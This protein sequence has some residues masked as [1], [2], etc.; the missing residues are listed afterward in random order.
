MKNS[1]RSI[2]TATCLLL[3]ATVFAQAPQAFNYQAVARNAGGQ[4]LANQNVGIRFTVSDA[5]S[6]GN[7]LFTETHAK[8]T[9]QFGLFTAEVGNGTAG[10]GTFST[11]NWGAGNR[12]LKVE[13]DP[14]GGTSYANLGT[15]QLLS[16][17]YA[18]YAGNTTAA[19]ATGT[20]GVK[21][22]TGE[23]GDTGAQGNAATDDQTLSWN[24]TNFT[25]SIS[26]GN[27]VV[28]PISGG[29]VGPTGNP[30]AAGANGTNGAMGATGAKGAT[31]DKGAT[32]TAGINGINGTN[33]TNGA[34][35]AT[36]VTGQAG[37]KYSTASA[38][39]LTISAG[40]KTLTVGTGLAYAI[41]QTVIIANSATNVMTGTV[42]AYNAATQT[43]TWNV[44]TMT[45]QS[46]RLFYLYSLM[47]VNAVLGDSV[48][49]TA[50]ASLT[51]ADVT[52]ANNTDT[53]ARLISGSY[54]PNDKA[55][56]PKGTGFEGKITPQDT[57]LSYFIRFQN[58]GT[59]TAFTVIIRDTLDSDL[60][61]STFKFDGASHPLEYTISGEGLVTF[62]FNN[63][64]L[65]DSFVNEPASHGYI[66]YF[67]D[68]KL[69]I[70]LGTQITNTAYIYFDFN[71]PIITNTTLNT[72]WDETV[73]INENEAFA[74]DIF[75][76]P[77][78]DNAVLKFNATE[79]IVSM[80][81]TDLRGREVYFTTSITH[82]NQIQLNRSEFNLSEG[83]YMVNLKTKNSSKTKRWVI[84]GK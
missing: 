62:T 55:V 35:G 3:S 74:F 18:L 79:P 56:T 38:T 2:I 70:P 57:T 43:A 65:A 21:G 26:G 11:I 33:G 27:S 76:N 36:G 81:I 46:S 82:S 54:D 48:H 49:A 72:L 37:D 73:G 30:G 53:Y 23:K 51:G 45:P 32:G 8:S 42:T 52:P 34:I 47:P 20:T 80:S 31:G 41:G 59:D 9:N 13:I 28:L 1:I 60:D 66:R 40:S 58:T 25:L 4:I 83:I 14:A 71:L 64:L 44:P 19:G 67:I 10:T 68:R 17:P 5:A 75:P 16:V 15:T 77:T 7:V 69:D 29:S 22:D 50:T 84:A 39:S 24:G 63:I 61:V 6:G 78:K 12:Y